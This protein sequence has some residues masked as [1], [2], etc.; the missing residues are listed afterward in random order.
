M[1]VITNHRFP[2]KIALYHGNKKWRLRV[3]IINEV[4][5]PLK[6]LGFMTSNS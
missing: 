3:G 2:R 6:T 1:N 5:K 4:R